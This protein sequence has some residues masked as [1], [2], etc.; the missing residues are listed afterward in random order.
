MKKN[1]K[2]FIS[3]K[4]NAIYKQCVIKYFTLIKCSENQA[5]F[6]EILAMYCCKLVKNSKCYN[7]RQ[8]SQLNQKEINMDK[9]EQNFFIDMNKVLWRK[10]FIDAGYLFGYSNFAMKRIVADNPN[11]NRKNQRGGLPPRELIALLDEVEFIILKNDDFEIMLS[12]LNCLFQQY[13]LS[14]I[15]Y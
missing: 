15:E 5:K 4:I 6:F 8:L 2:D 11:I 12:R 13:K 1:T 3:R 10:N 9:I 14:F 7:I